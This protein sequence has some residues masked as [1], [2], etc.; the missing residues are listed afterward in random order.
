MPRVWPV[1][2]AAVVLLLGGCSESAP[3]PT[4]Q[5]VVSSATTA[6][7]TTGLT[8]PLSD[9]CP[10]DAPAVLATATGLAAVPG[11]S[12]PP[13]R[14]WYR[15][16]AFG[17]CL[18]RVSD[19]RADLNPDDTS[20]G[21]T[22]E[23]SRAPAFNADGSLLLL[24]STEAT[25]YLYDAATLEPIR[26]VPLMVEPRWDPVDPDRIFY[27]DETQ[28]L[29]YDVDAQETSLVRDFAADLLGF[30][31]AAVWTRH[32]GRPS[33]DGRFWGLMAMDAD[34]QTVA[35][36]V[37][38]L[39]EG[40]VQ[41]REVGSLSG[42]SEGID[43]VTISPLGTYFLASF[44]RSC[45]EGTLGTDA[46]P[47]GLM[48]YDRDLSQGRG[49]LRIVGH[50]DSALDLTG[51]EVVVFQH[52][53]HDTIALLDLETGEVT[54][55]WPIDFGHTSIGLH[56][57]GLGYDRPGWAVVSTHDDD[58]TAHTWMDDQVF[59]VELALGGR[60]VRL[61]HTRSV[62]DDE[63]ELDYWAEPHAAADRSLTR[64]VFTT[65]WGRTGTGAVDAYLIALPSD[66]PD[67]LGG[68]PDDPEPGQA[69]PRIVAD[70]RAASVGAVP[71][72]WQRAARTV[73]W[74]YGSTSHG[75]QIWTGAQALA[76]I[77]PDL[78]PFAAEAGHVP[79]SGESPRLRM[80]YRDDWSW[81]A[82]T[83]YQ[84][85]IDLLEDVPGATAFMWSW[86]GELSDRDTDV[87]AYL[88]AMARLQADYPGVRFVYMTGHTD[89]D[90][91]T[92]RTNNDLIRSWAAQQSAPLY[93]FADI[94]S[95][96]PAGTYYP[97]T[98]DSCPWCDTWC[99]DHSG[100]CAILPSECA[101]SHAFNCLQKGRALWW[102]SARL[103]G[104]DG[105]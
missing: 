84:F 72:E 68:A 95:W 10:W 43:H 47:C 15:D 77:Y 91:P 54:N 90:N 38:D 17:T 37:Y 44:D 67:R 76:G 105:S 23:Y 25:W 71:D 103:A 99:A 34:W 79:P 36:L 93:D 1:T 28:L 88:D 35:F 7:A 30:D 82:S 16:P 69:A 60:V 104:W 32:E 27:I 46:D 100:E 21:I 66:W 4:N 45:E 78:Y 62:V 75:T 6:P 40:T 48:V 13:A 56:F 86:C 51:R 83:F 65:N 8:E 49:L 81:D 101:H 26:S 52:I 58:P 11:L 102:L 89:G 39:T 64:I 53:D 22:N 98:D 24:R 18:A 94:E 33:A 41:V 57:S 70:H 55:L 63:R 74:A 61:A 96:D 92:L 2:A 9:G 97:A 3:P 19:R 80:A 85:A 73:L 50:Y 59:L 31:L 29:A 20:T 12:E 14:Q 87:R 5:P 42:V